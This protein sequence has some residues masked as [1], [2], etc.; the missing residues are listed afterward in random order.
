MAAARCAAGRGKGLSGGDPQL[1]AYEVDARHELRDRMLDLQ[2]RVQFDEVEALVGTEQ[3]LEGSGVPVAD[4]LRGA[5]GGRFHRPARLRRDAR[6]RRLLDQLLMAA[7]DGA[8][9][10]AESQHAALRVG[11]HLD[12]HM[13]RRANEL[14]DVEAG[15]S[16]G[17]LGLGG[18][19]PER[20]LE[21]VLGVDDPHPLATAA[22]RS[23]EEHGI[24]ELGSHRAR[25]SGP[26][27]LFAARHE[28]N[29]RTL[30]L[31][32]RLHLVAHPGHHV[33]GRP[34]EDELVV[35]AGGDEGRVLGQKPVAGV[36]R[37]A[38]GRRCCGD[39]GR[40]VQVALR[41]RRR[42]D[43]DRAIREPDVHRLFVGGRVDRDRLDLELV[44]RADHADRDLA[45]VRYE[46]AGKHQRPSGRLSKASLAMPSKGCAGFAGAA[47]STRLAVARAFTAPAAFH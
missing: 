14:L 41:R 36:D 21:L 2:T 15:V 17:R 9:A 39:H 27:S 47:V 13:P 20:A 45:A 6:R 23:L 4:R 26:N 10:L 31:R 28:R 38:A 1:L 44:Q 32:L 35:L 3:E 46:D 34:H 29:V 24:S 25:L 33:R 19:G 40:D 18:G 22:C 42:S 5:L 37:L 16:E 43:G 11:K 7:L 12:L 8:L 30:H